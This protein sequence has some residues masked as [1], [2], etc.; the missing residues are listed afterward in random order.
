MNAAALEFFPHPSLLTT[1]YYSR[2]EGDF[3]PFFGAGD[4]IEIL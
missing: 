3:L 4:I 1:G 2:E